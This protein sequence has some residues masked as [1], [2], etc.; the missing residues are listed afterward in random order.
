MD[1]VDLRHDHV[2]L[3]TEAHRL[4]QDKIVRGFLRERRSQYD[5]WFQVHHYLARLGSWRRA[6]CSVVELGRHFPDVLGTFQVRRVPSLPDPNRKALEFDDD[7]SVVLERVFPNYKGT[8]IL[9]N[10]KTAVSTAETLAQRYRRVA[11][12]PVPHA[13]TRALHHFFLHKLSFV[14]GDRYVGCSKPSCYGCAKYFRFHPMRART[15]RTHN[16]VWMKWCL[17]SALAGEDGEAQRHG[18]RMMRVMADSIRSDVIALLLGDSGQPGA[19]FDS[20][21]GLT[22]SIQNPSC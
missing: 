4:R 15:G 12:F 11:Q 17:P 14:G 9:S 18:L 19:M 5:S 2:K 22:S 21:T 1:L 7:P 13:E 6:A 10:A 8:T 16:N 20:T 3:C